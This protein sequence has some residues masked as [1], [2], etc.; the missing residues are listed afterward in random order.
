MI[1][2]SQIRGII[3]KNKWDKQYMLLAPGG[4]KIKSSKEKKCRRN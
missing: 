2:E 4:K 3:K 1:F